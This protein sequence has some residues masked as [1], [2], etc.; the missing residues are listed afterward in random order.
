MFTAIFVVTSFLYPESDVTRD[1]RY[2]QDIKTRILLQYTLK[3]QRIVAVYCI[4]EYKV[5]RTATTLFT[6]TCHFCHV[7]HFLRTTLWRPSALL[8]RVWLRTVLKRPCDQRI[9]RLSMRRYPYVLR[10]PCQNCLAV[11]PM[12]YLFNGTLRSP[13]PLDWTRGQLFDWRPSRLVHYTVT[14][15]TGAHVCGSFVL[16]SRLC[17]LSTSSLSELCN[18]FSQLTPPPPRS[19]SQSLKSRLFWFEQCFQVMDMAS[20][21]TA[22][23]AHYSCWFVG[24]FPLLICIIRLWH[25][26]VNWSNNLCKSFLFSTASICVFSTHIMLNIFLPSLELIHSLISLN[27]VSI[28]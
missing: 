14:L 4:I 2:T 18:R 20:L 25:A 8:Y 13:T 28:K 15:Y 27:P 21:M 11:G 9:T 1:G 19:S 26:F 12:F 16:I 5:K 6:L 17:K 10:R 23:C 22:F 3:F 7:F 24:I